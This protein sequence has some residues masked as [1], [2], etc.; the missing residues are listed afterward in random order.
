MGSPARSGAG[1]ADGLGRVGQRV[2]MQR[3]S[4]RSGEGLDLRAVIVVGFRYGHAS[5]VLPGVAAGTD[6]AGDGRSV[7]PM[8]QRLAIPRR[9]TRNYRAR[10]KPASP[11]SA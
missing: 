11:R 2:G 6:D 4:R 3:R 7:S 10:P 8:P 5:I 9:P 1:D